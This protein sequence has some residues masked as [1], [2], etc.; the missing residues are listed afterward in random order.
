MPVLGRFTKATNSP[1]ARWSR[2]L[3]GKYPAAIG[4][5]PQNPMFSNQIEKNI[6]T[7]NIQHISLVSQ[8]D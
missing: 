3:G 1:R 7:D 8:P 2:Y 5:N 6:I 4:K